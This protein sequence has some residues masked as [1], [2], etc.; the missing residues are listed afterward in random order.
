MP[1]KCVMQL[2]TMVPKEKRKKRE[3][4]ERKRKEE[5]EEKRHS[6]LHMYFRIFTSRSS[7][8]MCPGLC[9]AF[10]NVVTVAAVV[11]VMFYFM[12]AAA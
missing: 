5:E 12:A 4:K 8:C 11:V 9:I 2:G 7:F 3:K 10:S 6:D 1:C